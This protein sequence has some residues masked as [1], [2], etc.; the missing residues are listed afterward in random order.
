[1]VFLFIYS[2]MI[3][4]RFSVGVGGKN[5]V[6]LSSLAGPAANLG[7]EDPAGIM[8]DLDIKSMA[9]EERCDSPILEGMDSELAKYAK[10][11][12]LKQAYQP[13]GPVNS[14]TRPS[15][16][17]TAAALN[18]SDKNNTLNLTFPIVNK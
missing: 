8:A 12:D 5:S 15:G 2:L 10:L 18:T 7:P 11:R 16:N 9:M 14:D 3:Y 4:I 6:S 1:M 17:R 13:V